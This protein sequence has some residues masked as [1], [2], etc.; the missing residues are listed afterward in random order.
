MTGVFV[1]D[2]PFGATVLADGRVR[3]R[4]WAPSAPS[5]SLVIEN[6]PEEPMEAIGGGWFERTT[7]S[8]GTGGGYRYRLPDGRTVPDPAARA[9]P[10]GAEGPS[11][12]VNPARYRWRTADWRGR[13]WTETVLYELHVGTFTPEGT[14][15]AAIGRLDA[16]ADL[17]VTAIELMPVATAPG[18]R[19]WGYDGVLPFAPHHAYGAPDDLKCLID[20][21]HARGLSVFLDVVYNHF[22][23]QGN[24][25]PLYAG[26]FFTER[27]HT[28]W[29]P[30]INYDGEDARPVRDFVIHNALYWLEEFRFDGL[31]L[32]AVHA[33]V[34]DSRPDILSELAATVRERLG[35]DRHI[36][37]VLENDAN[38]AAPLARA[39]DGRPRFYEAQW[40][41]DFHHAAHAL[42]T[43]ESDGYYQD[44]AADP[45]GRLL[46]TLTE[47]FAYRGEASPFRGGESRGEP[48]A[49]LPATAFVNFLQNHDQIGNRALGERLTRLSAPRAV[50]ALLGVLLLA[51]AVPMLFMG[52]EWGETRPFL[53]F[54]N[55]TGDL[56]VAVRDGR[57]AEFAAF[58][59]FAGAAERARIPDPN[60]LAAFQASKLDWD[61]AK[62]DLHRMRFS[63]VR[64]ALHVRR[65]EVIPRLEAKTGNGRLVERRDG[66]IIVRWDLSGGAILSLIANLAEDS[67]SDPPWPVGRMLFSSAPGEAVNH[68]LPG[69]TSVWYLSS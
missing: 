3:F 61:A 50:E 43:G 55:Y 56:A 45:L 68:R 34:D 20:A 29:G 52:E 37:L 33:I 22:G 27:H 9:Q 13:P 40:N 54:C 47:G 67:H 44:Y 4:L 18:E 21:A 65:R 63:F 7:S 66:M 5:V 62:G 23:P 38:T 46:A 14:F 10:K 53:Y 35:G 36:H 26:R 64:N 58:P 1:H 12:V 31:R 57:R 49:H 2:L 51:P 25:L 6:G 15:G 59:A 11:L 39:D 16:L 48:S 19:G 60:D 24:Y 8:I 41:D 69:W 32:D 30:A 28:P 42:V 17:G